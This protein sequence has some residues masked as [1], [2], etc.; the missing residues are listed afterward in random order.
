MI[1]SSHAQ[2]EMH[3]AGITEEEVAQCL[4]YGDLE[5]REVVNGEVRYGKYFG[6]KNKD[7]TVVYTFR[8]NAIRVV[9]VYQIQRKQWKR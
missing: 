2:Q 5:F 1:L 3:Q 6:L 7:I 4:E 8:K 9:T